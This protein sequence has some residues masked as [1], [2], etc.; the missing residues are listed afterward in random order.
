M[1]GDKIPVALQEQQI[2]LVH[3]IFRALSFVCQ[4]FAVLL[5]S[6]NIFCMPA[7]QADSSVHLCLNIPN[8]RQSLEDAVLNCLSETVLLPPDHSMRWSEINLAFV[9]NPEDCEEFR[10]QI[11]INGRKFCNVDLFASQ[12]GVATNFY[13]LMTFQTILW[14]P[15]CDLLF[16]KSPK[17]KL[18]ISDWTLLL[19]LFST[20][21]LVFRGLH[22]NLRGSAASH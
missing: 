2:N 4:S 6:F 11:F 21:Y 18:L 19:K 15:A 5:L 16:Q 13:C 9:G 20:K 7:T 17:T 8:F 10:R 14:F 1:C 12:K 22:L 3:L